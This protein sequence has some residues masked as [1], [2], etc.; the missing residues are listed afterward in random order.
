MKL[1]GKNKTIQLFSLSLLEKKRTRQCSW[2]QVKGK[3]KEA[4]SWP[5]E[6]QYGNNRHYTDTSFLYIIDRL[7][8]GQKKRVRILVDLLIRSVKIHEVLSDIS[9][10]G[11]I[12]RQDCQMRKS[13]MRRDVELNIVM[14]ERVILKSHMINR[15][16]E[17]CCVPL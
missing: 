3:A 4:S 17:Q 11:L 7:W 2:G 9:I 8:E 14:H 12:M 15:I 5:F 16:S 1:N 10:L 13:Q 6:Q